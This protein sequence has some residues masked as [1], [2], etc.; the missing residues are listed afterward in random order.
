MIRI[1]LNVSFQ[2]TE[3]YG[4]NPINS[5]KIKIKIY[6]FIQISGYKIPMDPFLQQ[7]PDHGPPSEITQ[8]NYIIKNH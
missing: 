2:N 8:Q 7:K 5:K 1:T 6:N 3:T 4:N